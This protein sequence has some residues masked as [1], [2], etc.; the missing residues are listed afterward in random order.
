VTW[1]RGFRVGAALATR[2]TSRIQQLDLPGPWDDGTLHL[3][4]RLAG[5]RPDADPRE[6]ARAWVRTDARTGEAVFVAVYATHERGGERYSNVAVPLPWSN[7]STVLHVDAFDGTAAGS[8]VELT[9]R[10]PGDPG[11]YLVTPAGAVSLPLAQ[12]FRVWPADAP[13]APADPTSGEAVAVATHEMWVFD[14]Q[15][16]TIRYGVVRETVV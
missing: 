5:V 16:L 4:S 12:R 7:L 1:H 2:L 15:F 11:L 9:T 8:G 14:R 6:G 10:A 13:G 3:R